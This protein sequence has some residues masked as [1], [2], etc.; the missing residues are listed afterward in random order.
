MRIIGNILWL[1]F[2][3][4]VLG[5]AWLAVGLLWCVT[6]VGIP[7][8]LQCLKLAGVSFLPFGKEIIPSAS[9]G[10]VLLNL[11]WLVFGG[12]ELALAYLALSVVLCCTIVGIPF[13][14]QAFKF[15]RLSL[16][17]FGAEV[18]SA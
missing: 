15:V 11:A 10:S 5:I 4:A 14:V 8:G 1:L 2:G 17:P 6:I 16:L 9:A 7:V 12:L 3:G 13:G 18:A